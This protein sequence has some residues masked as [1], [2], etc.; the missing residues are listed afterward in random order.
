MHRIQKLVP[1]VL[2]TV[3]MPG[4]SV[5][6]WGGYTEFQARTNGVGFSQFQ[7]YEAKAGVSYDIDKNFISPA[8]YRH[9][10]YL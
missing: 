8:G 5:H 4:D 1:G 10:S 7:Y 3:V 9:L 6:K 2:S